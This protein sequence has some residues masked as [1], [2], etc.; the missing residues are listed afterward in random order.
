M[1]SCSRLPCRTLVA[2]ALA[3]PAAAVLAQPQPA[4]ERSPWSFGAT[5]AAARFGE[6]DLSGG[7]RVKLEPIGL[8]LSAAYAPN[9]ATSVGVGLSQVLHRFEFSG[10]GPVASLDP[11]SDVRLTTLSLP[12]RFAVDRS[13]S[14]SFVPSY[15]LA[16]ASGAER[17]D[18]ARYGGVLSAAYV[19][20]PR[21]I[22][23]F[24]LSYFTGLDDDTVFPIIVVDWAI[25]DWR[26]TNPLSAGPTGPAGLELVR[27]LDDRWEAGV[28]GA[29]RSLR[30]RLADDAAAAPGG[31]ASYSG[32]LGFARV[33]Y[34]IAP[35][36]SLSLYAGGEFNGELEVYADG[37]RT[38]LS[39]DVGS[40]PMIGLALS[41]RF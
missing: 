18:S 2:L 34:R 7:G 15:Q 10:T 27:R 11:W 26:L 19:A 31:T 39:Q 22:V 1:P 21:R 40:A 23:G 9:P 24:G 6:S 38:V 4:T 33:S 16:R 36:L 25:D 13:W 8:S 12:M 41:G 5:L 14:V 30:F 20:G 28:G 37:G 3:G 17:D 35:Q 32:V 29:Y